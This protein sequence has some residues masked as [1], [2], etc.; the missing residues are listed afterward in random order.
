MSAHHWDTVVDFR[1]HKKVASP[2]WRALTALEQRTHACQSFPD[3]ALKAEW[4]W[5][6]KSASEFIKFRDD[7]SVGQHTG[8]HSLRLNQ[9]PGAILA[10]IDTS[11]SLQ[12]LE[13]ENVEITTETAFESKPVPDAVSA[14]Q[15]GVV[16][17]NEEEEDEL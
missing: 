6:N 16:S 3:E 17:V 8:N 7:L 11:A 2:H 5:E 9:P 13:I 1:W 4:A 12:N 10:R 14:H 15:R